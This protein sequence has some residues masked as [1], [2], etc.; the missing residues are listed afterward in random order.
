MCLLPEQPQPA[1]KLQS[2]ELAPQTAHRLSMLEL[3]KNNNKKNL[4]FPSVCLSTHM[5]SVTKGSSRITVE[6]NL[7]K[8]FK[9]LTAAILKAQ[10]RVI[11]ILTRYKAK[12]C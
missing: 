9:A 3:K 5:L 1:L 8:I 7:V 12:T 11:L 6:S 4:F 2:K 10:G